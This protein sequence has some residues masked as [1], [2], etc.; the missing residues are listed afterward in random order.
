MDKANISDQTL[1]SILLE[2]TNFKESFPGVSDVASFFY[3]I[4]QQIGPPLVFK[5][6]DI[7]TVGEYLAKLN[8]GDPIATKVYEKTINLCGF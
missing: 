5:R 4:I 2:D 3:Q 1:V 6:I 8:E 7:S